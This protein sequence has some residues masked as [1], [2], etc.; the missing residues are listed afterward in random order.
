MN[1]LFDILIEQS[2]IVIPPKPIVKPFKS[3]S[4]NLIYEKYDV[5][6]ETYL[7]NLLEGMNEVHESYFGASVSK[8][9][10]DLIR[11][12]VNLHYESFHHIKPVTTKTL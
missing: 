2:L 9:I 4:M 3:A 5:D 7:R 11:P 8:F 6:Q 10:V 1:F 12:F